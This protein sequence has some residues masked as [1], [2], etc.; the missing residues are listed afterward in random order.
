LA[1]IINIGLD[2]DD[3]NAEGARDTV[4]L[5]PRNPVFISG[6]LRSLAST[7]GRTEVSMSLLGSLRVPVE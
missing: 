2:V 6:L 7:S 4:Q 1:T 3:P 5:H